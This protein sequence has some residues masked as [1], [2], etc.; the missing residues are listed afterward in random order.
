MKFSEKLLFFLLAELPEQFPKMGSADSRCPD[1]SSV[2]T[3]DR[4]SADKLH[5]KNSFTISNLAI[6]YQYLPDLRRP[7]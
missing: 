2:S 5:V 4:L 7:G 3:V 6:Q 1:S